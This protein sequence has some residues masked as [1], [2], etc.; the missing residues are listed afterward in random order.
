VIAFGPDICHDFDI[1]ATKEWLEANGLGGY[2][3]STITGANTRRYHGLLVSALDPP[4]GR[5][6]LLSKLEETVAIR[7][8]EYDLSCNQY[9]GRI[10]PQGHLHLR[11][12]A[13]DPFPTFHY[14]LPTA[15]PARLERTVAMCQGLDAVIVRYRAIS[16]QG[17][18]SLIVRPVI[19]CRDYHQLMQE[20]TAFDTSVEI[21]G[22]RDLIAVRPY[23]GVPPLYV[24]L[25]GAY[26]ELWEDWYRSFEYREEEARGLDW[27]EDQWSPGFFTSLLVAGETRYL[28]AAT[29]PPDRLDPARLL[30]GERGRRSL[31]VRRWQ[32]APQPIRS[33]VAS[34]DTVVVT[35][36][37]PSPGAVAHS[38][39]AGYHWFEEWG[40]DAM[41]ALPG[42]TLVTGRYDV[43]RSVLETFAAHCDQ[44]MIPNRIPRPG[45]PPDY[46]TADATLWMFWAAHKYLDYTED[47]VFI[48][49]ALLP[50]FLDVI[51]WHV[52]GT[53]H[54]IKVDEDGLLRA[55][56]PTTQLTWMDAKVGD[57]VVTPRWGKP[58]EINALW[59]HALRF[60]EHLGAEHQGPSASAVAEQFAAR[61]WNEG[62]GYLNDVVDGEQP[63][64]SSLRPNQIIAV[65]LPYPILDPVRARGVVA[66][67]QRDLL[68][69]YGLR[70][71]SPSDPRY[72][73]RYLGDQRARDGAYHQGTAWPWLLGQF[74]TAYLGVAEDRA[75]AQAEARSW[76]AP[77]WDHLRDAGLNSIS[78]IF[79]GDPPHTPRGCIAQAWSVAE[80]LRAAV[81]DL[82]MARPADS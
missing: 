19:N 76:L 42:L 57:W 73:G 25:Q 36:P 44:G 45:S 79:D 21:G 48:R 14:E 8:S 78:E 15:G 2:A 71:L 80:I 59:H 33:L 5:T 34:A 32:D 55:G 62:A 82:G 66:A 29:Q 64:D 69:P 9:P 23:P 39:L 20:N 75:A 51:R 31:L 70:T 38:L 56:N 24:H 37:G 27:R 11:Q 28:I 65:S 6:V 49:D 47:E 72:C 61:F 13:L 40:R 17:S 77:I 18:I 26:F 41:I 53:R 60:I 68:T 12:F 67:V 74:I 63:A 4:A 7:D 16:C 81:E 22:G 58:V 30:D 46:N 10:H 50:I 54:G 1:A 3:S 52:T 35:R 43:A